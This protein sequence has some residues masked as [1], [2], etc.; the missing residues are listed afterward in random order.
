MG[1]VG[2]ADWG[3]EAKVETVKEEEVVMEVACMVAFQDQTQVSL[4]HL[5]DRQ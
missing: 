1:R 5:V 4:P 3:L 2:A